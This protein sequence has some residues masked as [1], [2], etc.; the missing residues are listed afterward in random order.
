VLPIFL[1]IAVGNLL[2]VLTEL[3]APLSAEFFTLMPLSAVFE[4]SALALFSANALRTLWPAPD[5][6]LR[7]GRVTPMTSVAVLL[8]EFPWLEDHL[9]AW[10]LAY[11]GRVRSVPRELTL[12]T[13]AASEG[14][15]PEE[16]VA[17]IN[18][19]LG[20]HPPEVERPPG[21]SRLSE[22]RMSNCFIK[23]PLSETTKSIS[24]AVF[25]WRRV[26]DARLLH[27]SPRPQH[28]RLSPRGAEDVFH[29]NA[30]HCQGIRNQGAVA[31]PGHRLGTHKERPFT[32]R[33]FQQLL[34]TLLELGRQHVIGVSLEGGILPARVRRVR[35]AAAQTAES[36]HMDVADAGLTQSLRKGVAAEL[37]VTPR[38]GHLPHV[39]DK[40]RSMSLQEPHELLQRSV[41]VADCPDG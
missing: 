33:P 18:E 29:G 38:T 27:A 12:G 22:P 9:F 40:G 39:H 10:G 41:G 3:A 1:L 20:Q 17:R 31:P 35:P 23:R 14:K 28:M 37:W 24:S 7:T 2:R 21:T 19:L 25:G 15:H 30:P 6:L 34:K 8:G 13:L 5:P 36:W 26:D 4:L 11:V 16:V 32:V